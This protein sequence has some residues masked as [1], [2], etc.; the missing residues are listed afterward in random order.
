M[1]NMENNLDGEKESLKL[2]PEQRKKKIIAICLAFFMGAAFLCVGLYLVKPQIL[3]SGNAVHVDAITQSCL[4]KSM[5]TNGKNSRSYEASFRYT[6][7][8][9]TYYGNQS[10]LS[11]CTPNRNIG[12]MVNPDIPQEY[13]V[14]ANL[15]TAIPFSLIGLFFLV[16]F[17]P[18]IIRH[19]PNDQTSKF[20]RMMTAL[21]NW[22]NRMSRN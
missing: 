19:D 11:R 5:N 16:V 10:G 20:N 4:T 2:T 6:I 8:N 7:D 18:L 14:L 17:I 13:M 12:L 21:D 9:Q 3:F 1:E 22:G 15:K